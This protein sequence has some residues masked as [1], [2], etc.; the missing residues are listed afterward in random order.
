ME[1][2][3]DVVCEKL[4]QVLLDFFETLSQ[5]YLE[6]AKLDQSMKSGYLNMSRARYNMGIKSVGISQCNE[7]T[8]TASLKVQVTEEKQ[9]IAA[10]G[11]ESELETEL[12]DLDLKSSEESSGSTVRRR[13]VKRS[14]VEDEIEHIEDVT[15]DSD[16]EKEICKNVKKNGV[17]KTVDPLKWFGILVPQSLRQSQ[18]DFKTAAQTALNIATLKVKLSSLQEEYSILLKTKETLQ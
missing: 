2:T 18:S 13:N 8:M 17:A 10:E 14:S 4:D 6:Q 1:A 9:L 15:L 5:L 12:A 11:V 16:K 7:N 3:K